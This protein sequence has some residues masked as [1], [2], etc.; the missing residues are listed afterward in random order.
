MYFLVTHT[1]DRYLEADREMANQQKIREQVM[2][3]STN[4]RISQYKTYCRINLCDFDPDDPKND[5]I[6]KA[7]IA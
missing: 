5:F 3:M 6:L 7:M 1:Y 2:A 4:E